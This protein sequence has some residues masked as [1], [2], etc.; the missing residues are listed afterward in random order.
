MSCMCSVNEDLH[1]EGGSLVKAAED[2]GY[3]DISDDELDDLIEAADDDQ[4]EKPT[5]S[6]GQSTSSSSSSSF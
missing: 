1:N 2:I 4:D 6:I 5:N 3:D